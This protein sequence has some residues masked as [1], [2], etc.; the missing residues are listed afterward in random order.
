MRNELSRRTFLKHAAA[1]SAATMPVAALAAPDRYAHDPAQLSDEEQLNACIAELKSI[2]ARMH[3]DCQM[4]THTDTTSVGGTR[5]I[6]FIATRGGR[7][8]GEG[9][10]EVELN[11]GQYIHVCH[12][13]QCWSDIDRQF[14]LL[15]ALIFDGHRVAPREIVYERDLVRKLEGD[16]L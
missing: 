3:P 11:H 8:D 9:L 1:G 2:L 4:P 10:Y 15:A 6:H 13:K 7:F 5:E 14:Y 12:V 16:A